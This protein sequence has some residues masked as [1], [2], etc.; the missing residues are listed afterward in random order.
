MAR[1]DSMAQAMQYTS[2]HTK[3]SYEG[4]RE[5]GAI[6]QV[7]L[8]GKGGAGRAFAAFHPAACVLAFGSPVPLS[9]NEMDAS[10]SISHMTICF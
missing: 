3:V 7:P 6:A 1:E 2:A 8:V 10:Y 5:Q 9:E 4:A